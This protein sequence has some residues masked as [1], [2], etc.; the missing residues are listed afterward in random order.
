[1]AFSLPP[2]ARS[3]FEKLGTC[4][5]HEQYGALSGPLGEVLDEIE[6]SLLRP[7]NVVEDDDERLL[8]PERLHEAPR[9][10]E[11]LG[12]SDFALCETDRPADL[13]GQIRCVGLRGEQ[14][15]D[16]GAGVDGRIRFR[17]RRSGPDDLGKRP[18]CDSFAVRGQRPR[19]TR[20]AFAASRTNSAT[21]RD[22]PDSRC[23]GR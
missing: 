20:A 9:S 21:R 2:P 16:L 15:L 23:R 6:K 19:S 13:G 8:A 12:E 10:E 3:N 14:R 5:A 7:V 1:M 4:H 11:R 17:E 18:E 22:F